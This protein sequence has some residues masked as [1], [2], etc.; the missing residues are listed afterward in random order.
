ME[1]IKMFI[2]F[3]QVES[4]AYYVFE[5][6]IQR[7]TSIPVAITPIR[8]SQ[9]KNVLVRPR[10]PLQSNEFAFSRWLVPY[11]CDYKGWAIFADCDMLCR[12]DLK[13][14]WDLRD[15]KYS[16]MVV[17]HNHKPKETVKYLDTAQLPYERKNWSSVMMFNCAKC[18][19]LTPEYVN[20]ASGLDLHQFKWLPG[21]EDIGT[22]PREWNHLVGYD[23]PTH[24]VKIAHFT[25]GGPYFN[26]FYGCE[27]SEEWMSEYRLMTHCEQRS[28]VQQA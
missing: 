5:N 23:D 25:I 24:K 1:S 21:E 18:K 10:H 11:L 15:D 28:K 4:V 2:G 16:V 3:D 14:L 13:E 19:T 12:S 17:K 9:L 7:N 6:S 22:L 26:E 20:T 27:F 8:L